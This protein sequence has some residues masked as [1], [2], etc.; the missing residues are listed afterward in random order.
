MS[1]MAKQYINQANRSENVLPAM[2]PEPRSIMT[3]AASRKIST[4][5]NRGSN[6]ANGKLKPFGYMS[7]RK[8]ITT[9]LSRYPIAMLKIVSQIS[10]LR[11]DFISGV[12]ALTLFYCSTNKYTNSYKTIPILNPSNG[13]V[14]V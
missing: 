1:H 6:G 8:Y 4:I 3:V 9:E 13:T 14:P 10:V 7:A 12:F 2:I 5:A 11:V